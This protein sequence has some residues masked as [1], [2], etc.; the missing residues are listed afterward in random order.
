GDPADTALLT[1]DEG[2][3]DVAHLLELPPEEIRVELLRL[4]RVARVQLHPYERI[5]HR[6]A[7]FHPPFLIQAADARDHPRS[8]GRRL[9][10]P[11][12]LIR[13]GRFRPGRC[14][15]AVLSA[16]RQ[17]WPAP[18]PRDRRARPWVAAPA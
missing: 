6:L 7:P 11:P 16:L 10:T 14:A 5:R 13:H 15:D 17:G 1:E 2:I 9:P 18:S 3:G 8:R 12:Q 4:L